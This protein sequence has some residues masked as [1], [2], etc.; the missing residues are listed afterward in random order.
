MAE[1]FRRVAHAVLVGTFGGKDISV[2]IRS[3]NFQS[4]TLL[5]NVL[6]VDISWE[7]TASAFSVTFLSLSLTG[8]ESSGIWSFAFFFP[9][10]GNP[11]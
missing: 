1:H 6:V 11:L 9:G 5:L 4:T 8:S 10:I 2:S 7:A 3:S